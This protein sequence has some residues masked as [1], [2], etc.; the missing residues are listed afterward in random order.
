MIGIYGVPPADLV[1]IAVDAVQFSPLIPGAASIEAQADGSLTGMTMLAPRGNLERRYAIAQALRATA[2]GAVVTVMAPKTKG[3]ARL[4]DDLTGFGCVAEQTARRHHRICTC[5]RPVTP[6]GLTDAI[7]QGGSSLV[8]D[9]GL[10]SQ[11][12]VF[13]WSRIDPGSA[14]LAQHLPE[15]GERGADF[16]CGVGVLALAVLKQP[17]VARLV[18]LDL[19]RRAIEAARRNVVDPRAEIVWADIRLHGSSGS[20][21][22]LDFVVMNPPFHDGGVEDQDLGRLFVARAADAL[23]PGGV[24]LIVA[25]RHLPYEAAMQ[26]LFKQITPLVQTG[27]Y[28]VYQGRK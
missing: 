4:H 14:L 9:I 22:P 8:G 7:A 21:G 13:S 19:D 10:W 12:G 27:S 18:M 25:N 24:C 20:L 11:P 5:S 6:T 16:G 23:R 17:K 26:P 1:T 28:K 2:P 3:G 15:L